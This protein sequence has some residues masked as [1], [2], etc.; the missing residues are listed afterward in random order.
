[1]FLLRSWNV[2]LHWGS[3]KRFE[4][5]KESRR[6]L[7]PHLRK[8]SSGVRGSFTRPP[9]ILGNAGG[10]ASIHGAPP[11]FRKRG[12]LICSSRSFSRGTLIH[13]ASV[14]RSGGSWT[15]MGGS[16]R[17]GTADC[18]ATAGGQPTY[19][20]DAEC[21]R[22]EGFVGSLSSSHEVRTSIIRTSFRRR[23]A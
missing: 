7:N 21:M 11:I 20:P 4:C 22:K 2:D 18:R 3:A 23:H 10:G 6:S 9:P 12:L 16:S 17:A 13:Q 8:V 15:G 19:H 1:M 5:G 14:A